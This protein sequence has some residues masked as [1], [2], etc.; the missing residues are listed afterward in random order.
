MQH[1]VIE[2]QFVQAS[3]SSFALENRAENLITGPVERKATVIEDY[4]SLWVPVG[5][6]AVIDAGLG[7]IVE[8][9][10]A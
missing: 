4:L 8:F 10:D 1:S 6:V 7:V 5:V 2:I 3:D 9:A